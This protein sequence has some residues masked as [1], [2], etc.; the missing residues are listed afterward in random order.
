LAVFAVLCAGV[1][2]V[3]VDDDFVRYFDEDV[4]FR[5]QAE[6]A[7][8]ELVGP[9]HMEVVVDS[10][11]E[12]GVFDPRLISLVSELTSHIRALDHVKVAVSLADVI[13]DVGVKL[14]PNEPISGMSDD[15][16]AQLFLAYELG[17]PEGG[18]TTDFVDEARRLARISVALEDVSS[19][20][21]K[22][23]RRSVESWFE[24]RSYDPLS[25]VV[26]GENVPVSELSEFNVRQLAWG[27][28]VAVFGT[29]FL[30][31]VYFGHWRFGVVGLFAMVVPVVA[32]F[33]LWGWLGIEVGLAT[34][35]I[36]AATIGVV[37]DDGVHLLY[38]QVS[39]MR[40]LGLGPEESAAYA[41]HRAG[42]AVVVTTLSL[43]L[44]FSVLYA[45]DYQV[46]SS[47]GVCASAIFGL[48]LA[49]DLLALPKMLVWA[50]NRT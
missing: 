23:I 31:G 14:A 19:S 3:Q 13:A 28:V 4:P 34:T 40:R 15:L 35:M 45:S 17:L 44:G 50:A 10:G 22:A 32:G 25:I 2:R 43:M 11:R 8:R 36:V 37:I 38:R 30:L 6:Y 48:A 5:I 20:Q 9:Y 49:F 39:S 21:A 16:I 47:F 24:V 27:I 33:G 29:A 7:T 18:T 42:T 46:N 26:T 41:V 12:S 1:V